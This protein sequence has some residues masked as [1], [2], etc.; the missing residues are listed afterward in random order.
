MDQTKLSIVKIEIDSFKKIRNLT[1]EPE[2]GANLFFGSFRSGKTSLCEFIQFALYGADSVSLARDNAEDALGRIFFSDSD[3]QY[4]IERSLI[5]GKEICNF[6]MLPEKKRVETELSPGEYLTGMDWD[7][8]D[9]ITYF[10]QA[11]YETPIFKPK[12]SFLKQISSFHEETQTIYQDEVLWKEKKDAFRN[13]E[14]SGLLDRL[15]EEQERLQKEILERPDWEAE[16]EK[17]TQSI[18][19]IVAKL[20]ENDRRSVLLKADMASFSDDL[21]L[22]RNKENAQDLHRRLQAKEKQCRILAFN[23]TKKIGLLTEEELD[24]MKSDYNRLSLAETALAEA[25]T[26]LSSAEENLVFHK[27]LFSEHDNKEH[28]EAERARILQN[29]RNRLIVMLLGI[30]F[31]AAGASLYFVLHF[32]N[33]KLITSLALS[34]AVLLLG[35]ALEFVSTVFSGTIKKILAEND[36]ASLSDFYEYYDRLCAHDKTTQVYLDQ[37]EHLAENC[38]MKSDAK[39]VIVSLIFEKISS[40]GYKESDGDLVAICDQIIEANDSLYDLKHEI[41]E[42]GAQ[43]RALL[44]EDVENETLE[45]S[46]EFAALQKEL[47][48]LSVQ[49]DSLYKKKTLLSSRLQEAN[50][51]LYKSEEENMEAL[52]R[53]QE[54]IEVQIR[55]FEATELNYTLAL[56]RKERFENDLKETLTRSINQK[57]SFVLNEGESFLFD[58]NFELC[59]R[60]RDSVLPL[61]AAGGGVVSE[62]GLLAFRLS[63]AELLG[64]TGLPMIFDDSFSMLSMD[65]AEKL[66]QVLQR[67]CSQFFITSSSEDF[68][69]LCKSSA[70]AFLL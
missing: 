45:V 9:L 22:S 54:Q 17:C 46:P 62:M 7:S 48:F 67:A 4:L 43:Y 30:V 15:M 40:L 26:A 20:D 10:K 27:K 52:S 57:I 68:L 18:A 6:V 12:F 3:R 60:D 11:R 63:L 34:G 47:A 31:M 14:K 16:A 55:E 58:E 5:A 66:Y 41:A 53:V 13:H 32:L 37:V 38:K 21:K 51:H 50:G 33:Y 64:K 61:I 69:G 39:E 59:F 1:I 19:E 29:K 8:F 25:R 42:D 24:D 28:Y 23:V 49:N 2:E 36:K 70:K 35:V 56:A 44:S 65:A